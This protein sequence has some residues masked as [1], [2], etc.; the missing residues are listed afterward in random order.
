[1]PCKH[2]PDDA[3]VDD[4]Y[5]GTLS[6]NLIGEHPPAAERLGEFRRNREQLFNGIALYIFPQTP[7]EL[8]IAYKKAL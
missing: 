1:M 8:A 5:R 4:E 7:A 6:I 2:P 3:L